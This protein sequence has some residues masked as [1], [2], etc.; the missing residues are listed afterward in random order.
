[1]LCNSVKRLLLMDV[2]ILVYKTSTIKLQCGTHF[3][4]DE[5]YVLCNGFILRMTLCECTL[6]PFF[7]GGM[8]VGENSM[9]RLF[10]L[11]IGHVLGRNYVQNIFPGFRYGVLKIFNNMF[12]VV[13]VHPNAPTQKIVARHCKLSP[14]SPVKHSALLNSFTFLT[15]YNQQ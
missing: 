2:A 5:L 11:N 7:G 13:C 14:L 10:F 15:P 8:R 4:K 3:S 9:L 1:M 12:Y 6:W